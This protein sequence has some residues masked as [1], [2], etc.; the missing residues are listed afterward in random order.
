MRYPI[1]LWVDHRLL[2]IRSRRRHVLM[3][4]GC[5]LIASA[6]LALIEI[7]SS[8][9][10]L[11]PIAAF[12]TALV[13][14]LAASSRFCLRLFAILKASCPRCRGLFFVSWHRLLFTLPYLADSCAH[15]GLSFKRQRPPA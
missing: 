12:A 13:L 9:K 6:S 15:C 8:S 7:P 11:L 1:H 3:E 10:S 14:Y 2:E 4:L 5:V